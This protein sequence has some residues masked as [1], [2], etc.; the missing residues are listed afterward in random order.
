MSAR[1]G[2]QYLEGL[3]DDRVVWLGSEK[4]DVLRHPA[5]AGSLRGIGDTKSVQYA[6]LLGYYVVGLPVA[7][8]LA[9]GLD[10]REQGLWWGLA[11]GL[12]VV[13]VLSVV[14]WAR[15]SRQVI[16]RA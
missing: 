3:R 10:W 15:L 12:G 1:T 6:N 7:A 11:V 9:F 16:E 8:V 5:F 2:Q 4:V 13:A 14:R